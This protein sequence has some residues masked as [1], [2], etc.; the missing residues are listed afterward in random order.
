[1]K[2]ENSVWWLNSFVKTILWWLNNFN[3]V[4]IKICIFTYLKDETYIFNMDFSLCKKKNVS[5]N[6]K[7]AN[8]PMF[9]LLNV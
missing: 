2:Q 6:L 1:M 3:F 7:L 5:K 4:K 9:F 8:A